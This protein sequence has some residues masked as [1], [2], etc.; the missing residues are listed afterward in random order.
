ML[1]KIASLSRKVAH[2]SLVLGVASLSAGLFLSFLPL[3]A[4]ADTLAQGEGNCGTGW[5][6]KDEAAPYEYNGDQIITSVKIKAGTQC[7]TYHNNTTDSCY[8]VTGLGTTHVQAENVTTSSECK[9]ISH[10]EFYSDSPPTP[11]NTPVTPSA[12]PTNT[13][14]FTATSTNT[15]TATATATN[16]PTPTATATNTPTPTAT[17]TGTIV[18]PTPTSTGTLV[19]PTPTSTG[20]L[21]PPTATP[22]GTPPSPTPTNVVLPP[23]PTAT[24]TTPATLPPPSAPTE[25]S[26]PP[27]LV[28]VTGI[29]SADLAVAAAAYQRLLLNLGVGLLGFALV[30]YGVGS[31]LKKL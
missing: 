19:P 29:D 9:Q 15:P 23:E 17:S 8:S 18:P 30:L 21:V 28:P 11:T 4:R 2:L 7:F 10:V 22:T 31:K 20:T 27:A 25:G 12:T 16:T 24:P 14:T 6:A 13:P 5:V 26:R 1:A 3:S